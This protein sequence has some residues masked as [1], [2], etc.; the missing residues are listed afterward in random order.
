MQVHVSLVSLHLYRSMEQVLVPVFLLSCQYI[1][2]GQCV[3][4]AEV[5]RLS[6]QIVQIRSKA[7][8]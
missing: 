7:L 6:A 1:H 2:A 4:F 3:V 8:E 5:R